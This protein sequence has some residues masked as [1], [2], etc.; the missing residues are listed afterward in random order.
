MRQVVL[1]FMVLS[2][3]VRAQVGFNHFIR[4]AKQ[5]HQ[6][7]TEKE[8]NSID[9]FLSITY[10]NHPELR[11]TSYRKIPIYTVFPFKKFTHEGY[12]L[13]HLYIFNDFKYDKSW[14]HN[15]FM[16]LNPYQLYLTHVVVASD[17][18]LNDIY[19]RS[20]RLD[21]KRHFQ[22]SLLSEYTRNSWNDF[23][24]IV[25]SIKPD[26]ILKFSQLDHF[27]LIKDESCMCI[28]QNF[29]SHIFSLV[30][31]EEYAATICGDDFSRIFYSYKP[32]D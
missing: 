12:F 13:N 8:K 6:A 30:S 3:N 1:L 15:V 9:R 7:L 26:M 10:K 20:P 23:Y 5:T 14:G 11:E 22:H 28:T 31:P 32:E 4:V 18:K 29:G 19:V 2:L 16:F 17:K 21:K 25:D 27:L 24:A